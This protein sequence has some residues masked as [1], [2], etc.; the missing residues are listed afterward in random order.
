MSG[1]LKTDEHNGSPGEVSEA[2]SLDALRCVA[3]NL[4]IH[5]LTSGNDILH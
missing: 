2:E 4:S 3:S 1:G 5:Y